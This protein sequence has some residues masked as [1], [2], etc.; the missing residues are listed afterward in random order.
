MR[1]ILPRSR[2]ISPDMRMSMTSFAHMTGAHLHRTL[3]GLEARLGA[4][5]NNGPDLAGV[6][7]QSESPIK[8]VGSSPIVSDSPPTDRDSDDAHF[9]YY[10]RKEREAKRR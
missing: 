3:G 4:A 9:E 10:N 8:P 1:R 7:H 6:C 5:H 2:S